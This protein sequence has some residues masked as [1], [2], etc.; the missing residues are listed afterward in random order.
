[1]REQEGC[2][3]LPNTLA[4]IWRMRSRVS[5]NITG[6]EPQQYQMVLALRALSREHEASISSIAERL[7]IR[8]SSSVDLIDGLVAQR[9]V[10]RDRSRGDH[11]QV[12]VIVLPRGQR[13]LER[14]VRDRLH[15]LRDSGHALIAALAAILEEANLPEPLLAF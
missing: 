4:S 2:R 15:E 8:H 11:W 10:R 6:L 3:S 9:Y 1:L 7:L 14:V 12:S 5:A 13:A